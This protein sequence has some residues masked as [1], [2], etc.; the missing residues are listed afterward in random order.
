MEP[1]RQA[2]PGVRTPATETPA[3]PEEP[4]IP[5]RWSLPKRIGF[6]FLFSYFVLFLLTGQ[7][8][9]RIPFSG[10]LIEKYTELWHAVAVWIGKHLFHI[11]YEIV[12]SGE[13][14]GDTTFRWILLLC[15]LILA[16]VVALVW[17]LLDRRRLD[18]ERLNQWLRLMLRFSLGLAMIVYGASKVI[19]NQMPTPFP[20]VLLQRVGELTPMR[21]LWIQIGA[22]PAYETF[23]GLA[24]LLG[25]VLLF[26]PRT[27]LLGAL[28]CAADTTMIFMLNLCYDVP[29]KIMSFHYLLMAVLLLAPDLRR[30]AGLFLFNRTV[31][32]APAPRLFARRRPDRIAQALFSLFGLYVLCVSLYESQQRYKLRHEALP[33]FYGAWE[34]EEFT[35]DGKAEPP[36][37]VAGWRWA[38]FQRPGAFMAE[39][40]NGTRRGYP[41]AV[42]RAKGTMRLGT[43]QRDAAGNV[44]VDAEGRPRKIA[45]W[46][47]E[48][49]FA[50]PE[51]GVLILD[52]RLEGRRTH[53]RLRRMTLS[54][55]NFHWIIDP[56]TE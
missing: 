20:F 43:Y 42:N 2:D 25:G 55:K 30:L 14:S 11:S 19:P 17:S 3:S 26:V 1:Q 38:A 46:P 8:V 56:F 48:L 10:W 51:P 44:I 22:S 4:R 33:P 28:I 9:D 16:G 40:T 31:E 39:L 29:V 45:G 50:Q 32:P 41:L 34:V 36:S 35:V 7:E 18:Y 27:T 6:R 13:G 23:T 49:A 15:Y 52:G 21:L 12:L 24:E 47:W 54:G 37:G 5:R 53:V